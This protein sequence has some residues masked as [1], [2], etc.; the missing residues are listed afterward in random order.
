MAEAAWRDR[1]GDCGERARSCRDRCRARGTDDR[2]D[3]SG[4]GRVRAFRR[5]V[6]LYRDA[7]PGP[8][9]HGDSRRSGE[10]QADGPAGYRRCWLWQDRGCAT[11]RRRGGAGRTP[12]RDRRADDRPR[13]PA[14]RDV[15]APVRGKRYRRRG[16][17]ASVWPGREGAGQGWACRRIDPGRGR[18]RGDCRQGRR[19]QGSGAGGDRRGAALRCGRQGEA[20]CAGRGSR[21]DAER[22]ADPADAAIGDDRVAGTVGDRDAACAPP[23]DPDRGGAFRRRYRPCRA[24]SRT[25]ARWAELR[26]RAADRRHGAVGRAAR[27]A[28]ARTRPRPGAWQDAGGGDRRGDGLVR[29]R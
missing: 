19:L 12:G 4:P 11:C 24:A 20:A 18:H 14:Y 2:S 28:R 22:D 15:R 9:D 27:Q 21:P 26:G 10:R 17:V 5:R 23:A 29:G 25:C 8:G 7:R 16:A 1:F 3:R 13:S 6:R